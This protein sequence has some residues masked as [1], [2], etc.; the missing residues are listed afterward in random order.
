MPRQSLL[1]ILYM[2]CFAYFFYPHNENDINKNNISFI[3]GF[4]HLYEKRTYQ[5]FFSFHNTPVTWNYNIYTIRQGQRILP[6]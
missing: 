3:F 6:K 5:F 2:Y 1:N 4:L